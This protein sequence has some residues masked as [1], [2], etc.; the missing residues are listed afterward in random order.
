[1]SDC[2][3]ELHKSNYLRFIHLIKKFR[4]LKAWIII[5]E[6]EASDAISREKRLKFKRQ[7][8]AEGYK[9]MK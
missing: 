2:V 8:A 5:L 1:M 3:I 6:G 9:M 4:L 7:I